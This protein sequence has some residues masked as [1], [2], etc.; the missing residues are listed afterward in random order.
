MS[1][2]IEIVIIESDGRRRQARLVANVP[3]YHMAER[4]LLQHFPN[5]NL[6]NA[7]QVAGQIAKEAIPGVVYHL[8]LGDWVSRSGW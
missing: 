5:S 6:P 2:P 3:N 1:E 7:Q 4:K 8:E